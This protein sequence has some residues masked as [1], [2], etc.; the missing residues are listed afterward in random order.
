MT[1]HTYIH[2]NKMARS[3]ERQELGE[4]NHSVV[5]TK[6]NRISINPKN[7]S[8]TELNRFIIEKI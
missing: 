2:T 4:D 5:E 1:I 8:V 3:V 6:Y 7:I